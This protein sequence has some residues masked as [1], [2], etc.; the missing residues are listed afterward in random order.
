MIQEVGDLSPKGRNGWFVIRVVR[1][2]FLISICKQ[3]QVGYRRISKNLSAKSFHPR[4]PTIES[5]IY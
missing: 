5:P 4:L 1:G 3:G 2:W